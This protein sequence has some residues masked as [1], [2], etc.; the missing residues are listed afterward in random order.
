MLHII[1]QYY[2]DPDPERQ[3]EIDDCF[4]RNLSCPWVKEVHNLVE[5]DTGIPE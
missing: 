2:N 4:Q 1:V 3:A 5:P